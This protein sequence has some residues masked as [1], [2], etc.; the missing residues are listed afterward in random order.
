[1][2]IRIFAM[3]CV[4]TVFS[5]NNTQA[6][7]VTPLKFA[8]GKTP[9]SLGVLVQTPPIEPNE[10][11]LEIKYAPLNTRKLSLTKNE[12][13]VRVDHFFENMSGKCSGKICFGMIP[14]PGLYFQSEKEDIQFLGATTGANTLF[15]VRF[16]F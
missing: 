14:I 5:P 10:A 8:L 9:N 11:T 12:A 7:T 13:D 2:Y 15:I 4:L 1:M 16:K 3:V 6:Q